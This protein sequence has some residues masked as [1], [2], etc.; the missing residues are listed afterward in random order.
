M[1]HKNK[2]LAGLIVV[3]GVVAILY[4]PILR[5]FGN[6][7]VVK[8][9]LKPVD[10]V[11]VIS[12]ESEGLRVA[13]GVELY[14][15]GYAKKLL[16]SGCKIAW[17]TN[18][19]D[20]MKRQAMFLGVPEKNIIV[21]REGCTTFAN[22]VN[23]LEIMKKYNHKNVIVVSSSYHTRRVS[24]IFNKV[25]KKSGIELLF[26]GAPDS[27]FNPNDWWKNEEAAKLVFYEYVKLVFYAFRY[28]E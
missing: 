7:L 1:Q 20:I 11:A 10:V 21:D 26:S 5:V 14:K 8:N 19:A 28:G 3:I 16:V 9:N 23:I 25:F 18:E 13:K 27:D 15:S 2:L 12:G 17:Q 22:A 24:I 6:Y 4:V